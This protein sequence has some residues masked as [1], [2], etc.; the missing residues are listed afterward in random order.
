[1]N[2]KVIISAALLALTSAPA[3]AQTTEAPQIDCAVAANAGLDICTVA[4]NNTAAPVTGF[5]P[6]AGAALG[7]AG[8]LALGL[9]AIIAIGAIAGGGD[10]GGTSG[11]N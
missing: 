4:L 11:T 6:L 9:G 8:P 1:M 3:F 10:S 2:T 7:A 5:T